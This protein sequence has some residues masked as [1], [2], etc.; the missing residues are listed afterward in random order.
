MTY[1]FQTLTHADLPMIRAWLAEPHIGGWWGEPNVEARL[2]EEEMEAKHRISQNLVLKSGT[3]FAYI[4]D[5]NAHA[6][7]APHYADLD[8]A[9]R[10]I[11]T[12]LGDPAFLGQGHASGYLRQRS[13]ELLDEG[14]T[15]IVVDPDPTNHRAIA[16]YE[17]AGFTGDRI[18]PCEDGDPVRIMTKHRSGGATL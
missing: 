3:P 17:S 14:A 8:P 2:M 11:D 15:L 6:W 7:D 18:A 4:Q 12:F 10:A 16:T 13:D 1:T 9:A 5:Y